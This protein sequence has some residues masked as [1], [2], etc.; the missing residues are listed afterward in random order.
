MFFSCCLTKEELRYRLSELEVVYLVWIY[1]RLCILL[2]SNNYWIVVLINHEVIRRIVH[3]SILNT[4]S[5]NCANRRFTNVSVYL[6]AYLLEVY[7]ISDRF[8]YMF[9]VL[10][11]FR[12][13]NDDT[14]YKNIAESVLDALWDED[15]EIEVE[16][17]FFIF[18]E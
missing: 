15:L 4:T 12:I 9:D 18:F 1:K 2:Y 6:S 7:Y 8:N 16:N 13:I 10:S 11:Y 5:T 14:V 17:L 3:Y